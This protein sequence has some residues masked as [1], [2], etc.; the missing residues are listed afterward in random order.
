VQEELAAWGR[1]AIAFNC[2]LDNC[3]GNLG[4]KAEHAIRVCAMQDEAQEWLVERSVRAR[5]ICLKQRE[6][7][8]YLFAK[9]ALR[10]RIVKAC[11]YLQ[12]RVSN[13][14][15]LIYSQEVAFTFLK[16]RVPQA[17]RHAETQREAQRWLAETSR[18]AIHVCNQNSRHAQEL[19]LLGRSALDHEKARI[20]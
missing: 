3:F 13:C 11:S 7:H 9:G 10:M 1:K 8:L 17:R 14:I 20:G 18:K 2:K 19:L 16:G 6:A 5:A 15:M 12:R 4:L